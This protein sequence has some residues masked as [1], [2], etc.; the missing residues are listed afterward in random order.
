MSKKNRSLDELDKS[1]AD[2]HTVR[3]LELKQFKDKVYPFTNVNSRKFARNLIVMLYAHWEGFIKN[4]SEYYLQYISHQNYK[5]NEL[6]LG[7]VTISHLKL[8][9]EYLESNVALK[10]TALDIL[11][12]SMN[13]KAMV[14]YDYQ[15]A[16][17][18]K[19]NT[20]SLKE[21]CMIVGIDPNKYVTKKGIIDEKLVKLRNEISHGSLVR[22]EP[23]DSIETYD[24]IIPILNEFKNDIL[25]SASQKKYL[26][27]NA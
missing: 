13:K 10:I 16:T 5:Y 9:N 26:L 20:E 1:I 27:S 6:K 23:E 15:I 12:N 19:L 11:F 2:E 4:C 22:I 14:P 8:V 21:I 7:L 24:L 3:L 25:N 17:Y 18:S